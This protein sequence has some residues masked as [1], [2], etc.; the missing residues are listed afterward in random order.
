MVLQNTLQKVYKIKI[1]IE[2][3]D[4]IYN[5]ANKIYQVYNKSLKEVLDKVRNNYIIDTL[6][7]IDTL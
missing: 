7:D 3:L 5:K 6:N 1:K 4:E 2:L